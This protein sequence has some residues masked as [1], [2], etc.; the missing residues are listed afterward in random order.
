MQVR[1]LLARTSG[2]QILSRVTYAQMTKTKTNW[3]LLA[4]TLLLIAPTIML[5]GYV[6][7]QLWGWFILPL[8]APQIDMWHACGVAT[9]TSYLLN[10][11]STELIVN[12]LDERD[13]NTKLLQAC[14]WGV[15]M[16]FFAWG[17]GAVFHAVM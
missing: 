7:S 12:S 2:E 14:A 4:I 13:T 9:F 11:G 16:P 5:R 1:A 6:L 3:K 8:G 15:F 10:N 17:L